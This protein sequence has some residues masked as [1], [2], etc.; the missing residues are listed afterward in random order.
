[1]Y[2][3]N[4]P[5][6]IRGY[7]SDPFCSMICNLPFRF[8][9]APCPLIPILVVPKLVYRETLGVLGRVTWVHGWIYVRFNCTDSEHN[10]TPVFHCFLV[11]KGAHL[12][13]GS[14]PKYAAAAAGFFSGGRVPEK[15]PKCYGYDSL[16]HFGITYTK[17]SQSQRKDVGYTK[18]SKWTKHLQWQIHKDTINI[19]QLINSLK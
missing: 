8:I 12:L 4:L 16:H 3:C 13:S 17:Q 11:N 9:F 10:N 2:W 6:T 7:H 18:I 15:G 5:L 14:V 1:M 19:Q